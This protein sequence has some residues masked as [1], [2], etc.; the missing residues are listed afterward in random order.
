MYKNIVQNEMNKF[1]CLLLIKLLLNPKNSYLPP[2]A[3]IIT[4]VP[5][6][7]RIIE[8]F[9][10]DIFRAEMNPLHASSSVHIDP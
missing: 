5:M 10:R 8:Q 1:L 3:Y 2:L 4:Y 6:R 7:M 9:L